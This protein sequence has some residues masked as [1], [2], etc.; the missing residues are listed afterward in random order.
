MPRFGGVGA[1]AIGGVASYFLGTNE[2]KKMENNCVL[3]KAMDGKHNLSVKHLLFR[4]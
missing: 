1:L 3:S 4:E 2:L